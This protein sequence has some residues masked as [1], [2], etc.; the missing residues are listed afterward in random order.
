MAQE[1]L[2]M[3]EVVW[4]VWTFVMGKE[5]TKLD[6]RASEEKRGGEIQRRLGNACC[7]SSRD[8]GESCAILHFLYEG[9]HP[10]QRAAGL[11]NSVFTV[12]Q[13]IET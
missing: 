2:G 12:Y 1:A 9:Q 6:L 13:Q 5:K 8:L 7:L 11:G 4:T 10:G 3:S